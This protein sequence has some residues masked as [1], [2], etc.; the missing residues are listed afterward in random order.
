MSAIT[1]IDVRLVT[2]NRS[3]AG[4]DGE[5]YVGICGR[6]FYLDSA[7]D[8][9]EQGSDRTY[10]L[11][12]GANINYAGYNDPRSPQLDTVD[13]DKFPKYIRLEPT[14]S[15][16]EWNLEEVTVTVNPGTGQVVY[17][18]LAGGLN[19]WLGQKYGKFCYLK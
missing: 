12:V 1:R 17:R 7:V 5:V 18:A 3:G 14:G 9:F 8:D 10:T 11:G 4:T 15:N 13:L 6:E 19:L 16:S 2:G